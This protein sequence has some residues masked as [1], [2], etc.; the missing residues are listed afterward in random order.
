M[1]CHN[2]TRVRCACTK[3]STF[4]VAWRK[5][6]IAKCAN[7]KLRQQIPSTKVKASN[8][9]FWHLE[10]GWWQLKDFWNFHPY[11]GSQIPNLTFAYFSEDFHLQLEKDAI[12]VCGHPPLWNSIYVHRRGQTVPLFGGMTVVFF[13]VQQI[14]LDQKTTRRPCLLKNLAGDAL[15]YAWRLGLTTMIRLGFYFHRP[16]RL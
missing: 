12:V 9:G 16:Q 2:G 7:K 13:Y 4:H 3:L 1:I 6:S 15:R 11:L 14:F 8:I 10:T 5:T